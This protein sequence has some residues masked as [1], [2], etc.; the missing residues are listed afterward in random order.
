VLHPIKKAVHRFG[1][2]YNRELCRGE[3]ESQVR[4]INERPVE[5][6]FVFDQLSQL[7]ARSLLDVGTGTTALPS[8]LRTCGYLVTAMDNVTDYWPDGF[9]NRH[10]YVLDDDIR[11]P[12]LRETFDVVTCISVIE[13]IPEH[14]AAIRSM[15]RLLNPGG[16]LIVTFAYNEAQYYPNVFDLPEVDPKF[17]GLPYICQIFS[18][19]EVTEW[20]ESNGMS[21][22]AEELWRLYT[23]EL[24]ACGG[25][26]V[27]PVRA[28]ANDKHHLMCLALRKGAAA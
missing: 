12:A 10:Y 26:I 18:R 4:K 14:Q 17:R 6:R 11:N 3:Y 27:P 9:S 23:G 8:L 24:I 5:F 2:W 1:A 20:V 7:N 19:R 15:C 13:H 21:I 25:N 28:G 22:A 16:R